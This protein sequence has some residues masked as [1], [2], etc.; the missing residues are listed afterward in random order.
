ML[1]FI[2]DERG[3]S[4]E[5][6]SLPALAVIMIGFSL[7]F[8]MIVGLYH[9]YSEEIKSIEDYQTADFILER[10][11]MSDGPLAKEGIMMDGGFINFKNF[12]KIDE[13]ILN[14]IRKESGIKSKNFA[15]KL[16]FEEKGFENSLIKGDLPNEYIS[17][18]KYVTVYLND[19]KRVPGILSVMV[20]E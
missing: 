16:E 17:V 20:W 11:T 18:S 4:E 14:K 19:V 3:I 15:L 7:L 12:E 8:I 6:T 5:F 9:S 10:I 1:S 2:R 13:N